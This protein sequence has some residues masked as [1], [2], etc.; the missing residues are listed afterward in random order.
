MSSR[1]GNSNINTVSR[2]FGIDSEDRK[3]SLDDQIYKDKRQ[4]QTIGEMFE[5]TSV[6]KTLRSQKLIIN[7]DYDRMWFR[8]NV[9]FIFSTGCIYD[10]EDDELFANILEIFQEN[11]RIAFLD[12]NIMVLDYNN[13][14]MKS[15][16]DK[17]A[18]SN[19]NYHVCCVPAVYK[20]ANTTNAPEGL[21]MRQGLLA[22]YISWEEITDFITSCVSKYGLLIARAKDKEDRPRK[23]LPE[24]V[25]WHIDKQI[26]PYDPDSIQWQ[27]SISTKAE[28]EETFRKRV[29]SSGI[30]KDGS[31]LGVLPKKN[32]MLDNESLM[33]RIRTEHSLPDS[34]VD[35]TKGGIL[36]FDE[37]KMPEAH[38][39]RIL[40]EDYSVYDNF[41]VAQK[42]T[43]LQKSPQTLYSLG[44]SEMTDPDV[45]VLAKSYM[46]VLESVKKKGRMPVKK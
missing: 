12:N 18:I 43:R 23:V 42:N 46:P 38:K 30:S 5:D 7:A 17:M 44:V 8:N 25:S 27:E 1:K 2:V 41:G 10:E 32:R 6:G 31:V 26:D 11:D 4:L 14:L 24:D 16:E 21:F 39:E 45:N 40:D 20:T 35:H 13:P 19:G 15:I 34:R 3:I 22:K 29:R 28:V 33:T 36:R 37:R 9:F